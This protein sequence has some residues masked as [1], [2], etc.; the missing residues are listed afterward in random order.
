MKHLINLERFKVH[1]ANKFKTTLNEI[2]EFLQLVV[3]RHEISELNYKE[4]ELL[5][6]E[7]KQKLLGFL[8]GYAFGVNPR[9]ARAIRLQLYA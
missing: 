7:S 8:A 4:F 3:F 2:D 6:G 5:I 1:L 9:L